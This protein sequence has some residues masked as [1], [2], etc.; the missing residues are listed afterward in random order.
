MQQLLKC[1]DL[2]CS[3]HSYSIE[4]L[5]NSIIETCVECSYLCVPSS[6]LNAQKHAKNLEG[7]AELVEPNREVDLFWHDI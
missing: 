3:L 7:W 4:F 2:G 5:F 6:F 1:N